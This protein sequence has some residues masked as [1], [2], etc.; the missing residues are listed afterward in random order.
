MITKERLKE[1]ADELEGYSFF[2]A[3]FHDVGSVGKAVAMDNVI[4]EQILALGAELEMI[5]KNG[6]LMN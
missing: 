4:P 5:G 1:L 3:V 6:I 2:L